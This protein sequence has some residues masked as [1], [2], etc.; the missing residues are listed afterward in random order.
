MMTWLKKTLKLIISAVV[1]FFT[2]VFFVFYLEKKE[3]KKRF[4][5]I[6]K[7]EAEIEKANPDFLIS[8]SNNA[9]DHKRRISEHK[10]AYRSRVQKRFS[11]NK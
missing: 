7:E 5:N 4:E 2:A 11:T 9:N 6:K 8:L 3:D 1:G 10:S